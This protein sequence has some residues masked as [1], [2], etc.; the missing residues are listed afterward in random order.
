MHCILWGRRPSNGVMCVM[1]RV[2]CL[3]EAH[4]PGQFSTP[5]PHQVWPTI[6]SVHRWPTPNPLLFLGRRVAPPRLADYPPTRSSPFSSQ[7]PFPSPF[8]CGPTSCATMSTRLGVCVCVRVC[9]C[10]CVCVCVCLI[11]GPALFESVS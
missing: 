6:L 1:G 10:A 9:V 2:E 4:L 7:M 5:M 11:V 3:Y 8:F